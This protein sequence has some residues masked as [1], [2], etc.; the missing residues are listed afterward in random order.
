MRLPRALGALV[1]LGLAAGC[2]TPGVK[3]GGAI[4]ALGGTAIGAVAG[5]AAIGAGGGLVLGALVGWWLADPD[6]RGPDRDG[7]RISDAQDNC[8][9]TPNKDQQDSNGDGRGD[10]CSS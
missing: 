10:A 3:D 7:D 8:P 4:G 5:N 6:A 1:W 9:D 2:A